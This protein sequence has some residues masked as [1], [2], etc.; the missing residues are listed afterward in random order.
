MFFEYD[1]AGPTGEQT[2]RA[3]LR[4]VGAASVAP[5]L[6]SIAA[7][8]GSTTLATL[9][10][11]TKIEMQQLAHGMIMAG[12]PTTLRVAVKTANDAPVTDLVDW[13]GMPGHAIV[14]S[15]N[16]S[17]SIHAH[18]MRPGTG[19]GEGHGGMHGGHGGMGA[20]AAA[21]VLDI[22]VTLPRAGLYKVF[23]QIKRGGRVVTA[24]FVL[25]AA[26]M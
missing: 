23:V 8:D 16:T 15:E 20:A 24:P 11:T 18:A 26:T 14:F 19:H 2:S 21:N 4:P 5:A 3:T 9:S 13:L 25:R 12:M 10:G 7:F 17:T 6:A 22:D 1:P